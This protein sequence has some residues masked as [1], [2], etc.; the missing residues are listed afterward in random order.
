MGAQ[1]EALKLAIKDEILGRYRTAKAKE[2]DI[3]SRSWLYG[4]FLPSL[5]RREEEALEEA[6]AEMIRE[7]IIRPTG[8]AKP[9]Y[10]I[11]RK[12]VE[13]LCL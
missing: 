5:S 1:K 9:T 11:T 7:G 6:L 3:L 13:L 12:G 8:G 10:G 2:G 4:E